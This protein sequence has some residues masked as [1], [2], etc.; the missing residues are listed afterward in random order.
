MFQTGIG[1]C[2]FTRVS[3]AL[4]LMKVI[5]TVR[6][7]QTELDFLENFS[8]SQDNISCDWELAQLRTYGRCNQGVFIR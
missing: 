4:T 1:L 7:S 8:S 2:P 6:K 5:L 3:M